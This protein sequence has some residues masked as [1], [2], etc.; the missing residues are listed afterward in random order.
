M[1]KNLLLKAEVRKGVGSKDA[2]VLRKNGRIPA[3]VYGHKQKAVV[4]SLNA[5]DTMEG[6]HHGHRIADIEIDGKKETAIFKDIQYD[7]LGKDVIHV[8]LMRVDAEERMMQFLEEL[9]YGS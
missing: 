9:G 7:Y 8:D 5:H 4:I 2:T 1:E 6:L 3:V